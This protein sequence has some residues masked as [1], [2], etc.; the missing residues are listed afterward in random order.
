MTAMFDHWTVWRSQHLRV[1]DVSPE[2]TDSKLFWGPIDELEW[3]SLVKIVTLVHRSLAALKVE[4]MADLTA[5]LEDQCFPSEK[6]RKVLRDLNYI[7]RAPI[8]PVS[9]FESPEI[10]C[11]WMWQCMNV[12]HRGGIMTINNAL[13]SLISLSQFVTPSMTFNYGMSYLLSIDLFSS[14]C[15]L[16]PNVARTLNKFGYGVAVQST[17]FRAAGMSYALS[18]VLAWRNLLPERV[19]VH[20]L[21]TSNSHHRRHPRGLLSSMDLSS[22]STA[23]HPDPH[24]VPHAMFGGIGH[25]TSISGVYRLLFNYSHAALEYERDHGIVEIVQDPVTLEVSGHGIDTLRGTFKVLDGRSSQRREADNARAASGFHQIVFNGGLIAIPSHMVIVYSDGTH[26]LIEPGDNVFSLGGTLSKIE[27]LQG[28]TDPDYSHAPA[29]VFG[30]FTLLYDHGIT[31][32]EGEARESLWK[33]EVDEISQKPPI[34]AE[35]IPYRVAQYI[36]SQHAV[37]APWNHTTETDYDTVNTVIIRY[38]EVISM[39]LT[40]PSYVDL[41]EVIEEFADRQRQPF[42]EIPTLVMNVGRETQTIYELRSDLWKTVVAGLIH[43]LANVI[44]YFMSKE[45]VS[46][47]NTRIQLVGDMTEAD[48]EEAIADMQN[49]LSQVWEALRLHPNHRFLLTSSARFFHAALYSF[50]DSEEDG[51]SFMNALGGATSSSSSG[52][53][54][55]KSRS[56]GLMKWFKSPIGMIIT[57]VSFSLSVGIA[58]FVAGRLVARSSAAK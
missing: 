37:F 18:S 3:K 15:W 58:A 24:H 20:P 7:F 4:D 41:L 9:D 42:P 31:T 45:H 38:N 53:S 57:A 25:R 55:R 1:L 56:G 27:P 5:G 2:E 10:I 46:E 19:Q 40:N 52:S 22:S 47:I 13:D 12:Y 26:L 32:A 51:A 23:L 28:V 39:L 50:P 30:G 49:F 43:T 48:G 21:N 16:R 17:K 29:K 11:L 36:R 54:N 6:A 35:P 8:S 34:T 44:P 33:A 14:Y